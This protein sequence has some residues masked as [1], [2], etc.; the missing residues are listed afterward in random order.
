M[1]REHLHMPQRHSYVLNNLV[2]GWGSSGITLTLQMRKLTHRDVKY[3]S[4]WAVGVQANTWM[5]SVGQSKINTT[6]EE[7]VEGSSLARVPSC[8]FLPGEFD[9]SFKIQPYA[10]VFGKAFSYPSLQQRWPL[11][12][13]T[14]PARVIALPSLITLCDNC[15]I[16]AP[17][18]G[19]ELLESRGKTVH[20]GPPQHRAWHRI[21]S[22]EWY[23]SKSGLQVLLGWLSG[24]ESACQC[25]KWGFH[26]WVGKIPW[27]N[28]MVTHS[29]ILTWTILWTEEFGK[30]QSMGLQRVVH[31]LVT[32]H[33]H[34]LT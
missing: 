10:C 24:K 14:P 30:L 4:K 19:C 16:F 18:T 28:I 31:N 15:F 12:W 5:V 27:R 21:T 1:H 29:S 13:L 2:L 11:L 33:K 17:L 25:R 22:E 26:P 32:E 6:R 9:M 34:R 23:S 3:G 20:P 7:S 8:A